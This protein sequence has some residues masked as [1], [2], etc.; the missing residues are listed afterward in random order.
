MAAIAVGRITG[1]EMTFSHQP[2]FCA[3]CGAPKMDAVIN[4]TH[5]MS[6][7]CSE[8]CRRE[9]SIKYARMVLGKPAGLIP[10]DSAK[11][12]PA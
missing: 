6:M 10:P 2:Y 11:G 7:L 3:N 12:D 5:V 4:M 9:W 1:C 8:A